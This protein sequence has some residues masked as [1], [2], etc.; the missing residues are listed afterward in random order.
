M[1]SLC[2]VESTLTQLLV[3]NTLEKKI[4]TKQLALAM[5][6]VVL[7]TLRPDSSVRIEPNVDIQITEIPS[8]PWLVSASRKLTVNFHYS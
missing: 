4:R 8:C 2:A 6:E 7:M 3:A 5:C 1:E